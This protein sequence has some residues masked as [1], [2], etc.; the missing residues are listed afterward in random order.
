[1]VRN[2]DIEQI[3][4]RPC[5][6][7]DALHKLLYAFARLGRHEDGIGMRFGQAARS[8]VGFKQVFLIEDGKPFDS[9]GAD[10]MQHV[11][12]RFH[13]VRQLI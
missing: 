6:L 12:D 8:I 4:A 10:L 7:G 5:N 2:H 9:L 1:M 11:L 3:I 13:L